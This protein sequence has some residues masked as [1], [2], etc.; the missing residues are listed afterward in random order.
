MRIND[1][2]HRLGEIPLDAILDALDGKDICDMAIARDL[3]VYDIGRI[4]P[5]PTLEDVGHRLVDYYI[6][7]IMRNPKKKDCVQVH[8]PFEAAK[9]LQR[10]FEFWVSSE[11]S[12]VVNQIDYLVHAVTELYRRSNE[13]IRN[14]L[15]TGFLEHVFEIKNNRH[16]FD[17]WKAPP[18][19]DAFSASERWG[20]SHPRTKDSENNMN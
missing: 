5:R 1:Y 11:S 19:A 20:D 10:L 12:Q 15:E 17:H 14:I 2:Q 7:C 6:K 13:K 4:N 9:E 16:F 3:L 8:S 18:F